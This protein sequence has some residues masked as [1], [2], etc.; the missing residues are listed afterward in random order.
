MNAREVALVEATVAA[1]VVAA[2]QDAALQLIAPDGMGGGEVAGLRRARLDGDG[3]ELHRSW[4]GR[5]T[6]LERLR[7]RQH[8]LVAR[9]EPPPG[10]VGVVRPGPY[11][12]SGRKEEDDVARD[13]E[14]ERAAAGD[15][16]A[17]LPVL[18]QQAA[19][20]AQIDRPQ[21]QLALRAPRRAQEHVPQRDVLVSREDHVAALV[22]SEDQ[23]GD[24][25]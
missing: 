9:A 5:R 23:V 3:G 17:A 22:A 20:R 8:L 18:G 15:G 2:D 7:R 14:E 19:A 11:Q 6:R 12:R 16:L 24:P 4:R 21:V 10:L 25:G 13:S 1:P